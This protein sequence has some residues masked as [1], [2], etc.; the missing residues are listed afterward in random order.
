MQSQLQRFLPELTETEVSSMLDTDQ[1]FQL[2]KAEL[3]TD[4]GVVSMPYIFVTITITL[5]VGM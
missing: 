4:L 2:Q 1:E 3:I 5:A